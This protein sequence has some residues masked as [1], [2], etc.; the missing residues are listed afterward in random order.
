[1]EQRTVDKVKVKSVLV[2]SIT[3]EEGVKVDKED[4]GRDAVM[5]EMDVLGVPIL[6]VIG[7]KRTT[8]TH[9]DILFYPIY[10]VINK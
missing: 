7:T 8:Y 2:P 6:I 9:K 4:K 1:M 3:Y 5:Y 10:L